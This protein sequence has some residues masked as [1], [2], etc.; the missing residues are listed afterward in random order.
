M[1][2]IG[3][4]TPEQKVLREWFA[5]QA[6]QNLE[7]LE[8]SAQSITQL[9]TGL[10]GVLF[11]VLAFSD[12]P[13]YLKQTSV[14]VLGLLSMIALF[15]ALLAALVVQFPLKSTFHPDGLSEMEAIQGRLLGRK[16]WGLR[17]ALLLFI[18]GMGLLGG[19]IGVVLLS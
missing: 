13:A 19:L 10:Y 7:R 16:T 6:K 4:E 8:A 15:G 9:V 5:E 11:A 1:R 17:A 2:P 3:P 12:S 14:Q 18:L